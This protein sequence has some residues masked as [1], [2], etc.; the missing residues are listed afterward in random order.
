[1]TTTSALR[2]TL[3]T[4]TTVV[5]ACLFLAALGSARAAAPGD[6]PDPA[7]SAITAQYARTAPVPAA[8]AVVNGDHT[9]YGG[10]HGAGPDTPFIIGSV[11]KSFT[12]LAVL[13]LV[14]RGQLDLDNPVQTYLPDLRL[15]R[16]GEPVTLR[17]LLSHTAGINRAD[18]N[19]DAERTYAS[20]AARVDDNRAAQLQTAPGSS[21]EYCNVGYAILARIVEV[22]AGRPFAE[23]LQADVLGP[24][25][26]TRTHT[27]LTSA[28]AADL[29][30]GRTTV[31]GVPVTWPEDVR[32]SALPD[33]YVVSTVRDLAAYSRFQ[34]GDGTG[35][36]GQ[37]LLSSRL[38]QEMHTTQIA[39]PGVPPEMAGYGLGWFVGA[40]GARTVV[41]HGGTNLRYQADL[42]MLPAD[43][44]AVVSLAAGQ[45]LAG[46]K[47]L[48]DASIAGLLDRETEPTPVYQISTA[49]LWLAVVALVM[50]V[51]G[52]VVR[53]RR[54]RA[55]G[56]RPRR[57]AVAPVMSGAGLLPVV[58]MVPAIQE[59]GSLSASAPVPGPGRTRPPCP[60]GPLDADAALGGPE[61]LGRPSP[62]SDPRPC[63]N[64]GGPPPRDPPMTSSSPRSLDVPRP[65]ARREARPAG[66]HR[67][68]GA[69]RRT[70]GSRVRPAPAG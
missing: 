39:V 46:T 57:W 11:S 34:M 38:L 45:W 68:H 40:D 59:L 17:H 32:P 10:Q 63:G 41:W 26:L 16:E 66:A 50:T 53:R 19:K 14:Q 6:A 12:A 52:S 5:L 44:R 8:Y 65:C 56:R 36:D 54:R 64:P 43:G 70:P 13:V 29:A 35:A 30:Q 60:G 23:V 24:L 49:V 62:D 4:V 21:F 31:L 51:L 55:T 18:C 58:F 33:G 48:T 67:S 61:G 25:A 15:E 42:A 2:C 7:A 69:L 3:T 20:L 9:L 37:R 47:P 22:E 1:M 28:R 27:D